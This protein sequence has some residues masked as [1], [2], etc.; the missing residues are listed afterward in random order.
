MRKVV[1][2]ILCWLA[3]SSASAAADE[4]R[5][6]SLAVSPVRAELR[7]APGQNYTGL[8]RVDVTTPAQEAGTAAPQDGEAFSVIVYAQDWFLPLE[9]PPVYLAPGSTSASCAS[10][11]ATNPTQFGLRP[12]ESQWLRYTISVPEETIGEH[13]TVLFV[14]AYPLLSSEQRPAVTVHARI[15]VMIYVAV[16]DALGEL[17]ILDFYAG[18][19]TAVLTLANTGTAHL[20]VQGT[21][22]L[23]PSAGEP[24]TL[25]VPET[26]ILP[27]EHNLRRVQ[28]ALTEATSG[29]N[30]LCSA[31]AL[32]DY[33]GEAIL[34]AETQFVI[35]HE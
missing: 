28:V 3:V 6:I 31:T 8:I 30:G 23:A 33:G 14:D 16:G 5:P 19:S 25:P 15:G 18:P 1:S 13:W 20:R 11:V 17:Q 32:L 9:G 24:T 4:Q 7:L 12:G 26:V 10:W 2:L 27:G 34:G 29:W 21:I 35:G 22:S